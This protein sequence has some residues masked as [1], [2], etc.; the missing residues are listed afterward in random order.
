MMETQTNESAFFDW[1]SKQVSPAQLS[2]LYTV[3]SDINEFCLSRKVLKTSLFQTADISVLAKVRS[4]VESDKVFAFKYKKKRKQMIQGIHYYIRFVKETHPKSQETA[5]VELPSV[6]PAA[7]SEEKSKPGTILDMIIQDNVPYIDNRDKAGCLW[8]VGGE[9]LKPLVE[10]YKSFGVLFR[11]KESSRAIGGQPAWW[12]NDEI[13]CT[14]TTSGSNLDMM[15]KENR[16]EFIS[17]MMASNIDSSATMMNLLYLKK[18]GEFACKAEYLS[19]DT[20][21]L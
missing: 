9:E 4:T 12:T 13:K 17:W 16:S 8:I 10:K 14:S 6:L 5:P 20:L 2:D 21:F 3:F 18:C 11:Y 15:A 1:L 19:K 7:L